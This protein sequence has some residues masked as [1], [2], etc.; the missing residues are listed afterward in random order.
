MAV[1]MLTGLGQIARGMEHSVDI[2][3]AATGAYPQWQDAAGRGVP[4]R[5]RSALPSRPVTTANNGH[6]GSE[7]GSVARGGSLLRTSEEILLESLQIVGVDPKS[8]ARLVFGVGSPHLDDAHCPVE[9]FGARLKSIE[10]RDESAKILNLVRA[11]PR[12][13]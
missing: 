4:T 10:Q 9:F 13:R 5:P 7:R 3:A 1:R 2:T 8:A 6:S 12:L 11:V